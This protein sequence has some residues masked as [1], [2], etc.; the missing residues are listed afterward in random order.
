LDFT[1][2]QTINAQIYVLEDVLAEA[3]AAMDD[4][5]P[6]QYLSVS[7]GGPP[8]RGFVNSITPIFDINYPERLQ[9]AIIYP[10]PVWLRYIANAI[11]IIVPKRTR[12]KFVMFSDEPDLLE[13]LGM[14]S[15]QL[16]EDLKGGIEA[17]RIRREKALQDQAR[18]DQMPEGFADA[19]AQGDQEVSVAMSQAAC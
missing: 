9:T 12:E 14:T 7:T 2:K 1:E 5:E 3:D 10:I 19:V 11:L 15:D 8:P 17:S 4:G 6:A 16:P 18:R 13:K